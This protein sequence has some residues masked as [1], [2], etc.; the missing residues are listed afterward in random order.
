VINPKF[1]KTEQNKDK[2]N[3]FF[4]ETKVGACAHVIVVNGVPKVYDS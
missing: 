4:K 1:L 3:E 2:T